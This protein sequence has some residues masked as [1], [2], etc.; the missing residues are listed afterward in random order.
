LYNRLEVSSVFIP[1]FPYSQHTTVVCW[2]GG[3]NKYQGDEPDWYSA[4]LHTSRLSLA[5]GRKKGMNG[6]VP[7][8][9]RKAVHWTLYRAIVFCRNYMAGKSA[10]L[11]L[12]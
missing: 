11:R 5:F 7:V 2:G 12:V 4:T 6:H 10:D 1:R 9:V 3:L 8:H